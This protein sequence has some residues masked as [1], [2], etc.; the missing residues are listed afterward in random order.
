MRE[1]QEAIVERLRDLGPQRVLEVGVGTGLILWR[2]APHCAAYWA[3][4]LS[5]PA[6]EALRSKLDEEPTLRDRIT[7]RAQAAHRFDGL[8][9]CFF[10]TVVLNSVVQYFPSGTYLVKVLQ[11]A[12]AL[13]QPG[14]RIVIGDVRNLRLLECFATAVALRKATPGT[15]VSQLRG[16]IAQ[17]V[18]L[19]KELLLDPGFFSALSEE[20][21][22]LAG[23][24]IQLKRGRSHNEL[25]RYRYE[26]L[27]H[28]QPAQT[29]SLQQCQRLL[30]GADI[31]HSD[32]LVQRLST[33]R[34]A[35]LRISG[36]PNRRVVA[37]YAAMQAL[38]DSD[39]LEDAQRVLEGGVPGETAREPEEFHDLARQLGYRISTTWSAAA[40][41]HFDVLLMAEA[42]GSAAL[43]D[44][45]VPARSPAHFSAYVNDPTATDA[46]RALV[47]DLRRRGR[48]APRLPG[49]RSHRAIAGSAAHS[50]WQA[51]S[52][53]AAGTGVYPDKQPRT[54]DIARR[55]SRP[56]VRRGV[57]TRASRDR[58]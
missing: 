10:D 24:D 57:G 27:L 17:S 4:D 8:P 55:D 26:V 6:I 39:V 20:I 43:T 1:W 50:Q 28:K 22:D 23:V 48:S 19:E 15:T 49:A 32:T 35:C 51:R 45:Y 3:T 16:L 7:L 56:T 9:N 54:L 31:T 58:R 47:L 5:A 2:L 29:R 13:L 25:T 52:Q 46:A 38:H 33:D 21:P 37:E 18:R 42:G 53:G 12:M 30:W 40:P 44:L 11:Q 34:P 14:G 36:I 41:E